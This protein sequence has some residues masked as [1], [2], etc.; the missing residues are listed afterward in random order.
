MRTKIIIV[1]LLLLIL[2]ISA[3]FINKQNK[4][5]APQR[6]EMIHEKGMNVMP[7]NLDET[8]HIFKKT[9]TG[10]TQTIV[11][12]DINDIDNLVLIRLHLKM[13]A[14]N[15]S[16]GNFRDPVGLH[17]ETMPG[18]SVLM[19]NFPKM[20]VSYTEIEAG[21]KIDFKTTDTK[22]IT[23]IHEWFDA[24]VSDHGKDASME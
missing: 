9:E 10:G 18:I 22:T 13:E 4:E 20:E 5:A 14:K 1:L 7:F 3:F 16:K 8:E 21:A 11:V 2:S 6:Q 17:G 19:I 23:A 12:R 24:Q 15:F